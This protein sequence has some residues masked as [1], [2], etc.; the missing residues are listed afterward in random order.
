[1]QAPLSRKAGWAI[2]L[3]ATLAM[4]VSYVDRQTLAALAPTVC[5]ALKI[6]ATHYGWLTSAFSLSYLVGAPLAGWMLDRVEARRGL[7]FSVLVWSAVSAAHAWVPSFGVLFLLR[8]ALGAAEAPSF[9]GAAQTVGR[10]LPPGDRSTGYGLIFTGSSIGAMF[11]APLAIWLTIHFGWQ[12]AFIGTA[13]AGLVWIPL[14]LLVTR[15]PAARAAMGAPAAPDTPRA[16]APRVAHDAHAAYDPIGSPLRLLGNPAVLRAAVL[17]FV[18]APG[19]M[20]VLNWYSKYLVLAHGLTQNDLG[21]YLWLP[22]VLFDIGAV[23]FGMLAS[24]RDRRHASPRSHVELVMAGA[25]LA[26]ALALV[27]FV[28]DPV[29]AVI[30]GGIAMAGGGACYV[31]ATADML[32]RVDPR[33]ASRAGGFTAASQS[34]AHIIAGPLIGAVVDRTHSY[35]SVLIVLGLMIVPGAIAW[36]AWP[37]PEPGR[38]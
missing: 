34:L 36:I 11:A 30:L 28:H 25:G 10:V 8:V 29:I 32:R 21:K 15:S 20:F 38:V 23:G 5:S 1:M 13:L 17:V 26:S 22:P 37:M 12:R 18:S 31:V 9:P 4:T 14:W 24:R 2:A 19:L 6:D 27:P 35:T 33:A 3:V 7:V 16:N